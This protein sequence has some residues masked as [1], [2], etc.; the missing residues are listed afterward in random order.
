MRD[1]RRETGETLARACTPL[2]KSEKKG[3][4]RE[5]ARNLSNYCHGGRPKRALNSIHEKFN[6]FKTA[7]PSQSG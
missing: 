3:K 1:E 4:E 7:Q 2:N 6:V 5:P